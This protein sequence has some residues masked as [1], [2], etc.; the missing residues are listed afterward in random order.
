MWK[1]RKKEKRWADKFLLSLNS[2]LDKTPW[3][4]SHTFL[5][6]HIIPQHLH[7]DIFD[8]IMISESDSVRICATTSR[9]K[10]EW[11]HFLVTKSFLWGSWVT[12]WQPADSCVSG[13]GRCWCLCRCPWWEEPCLWYC[14]CHCSPGGWGWTEPSAVNPLPAAWPQTLK[15]RHSHSVVSLSAACCTSHI[16]FSEGERERS[17]CT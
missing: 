17:L 10:R 8:Q 9:H 5:Y 12:S 14:I 11:P 15:D 4:V 6:L 1:K 3:S 2:A 13:P 7:C 16:V